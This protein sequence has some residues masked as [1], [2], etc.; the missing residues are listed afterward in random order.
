[1]G[2]FSAAIAF[3]IETY[4]RLTC[5]G[6]S[7]TA[8]ATDRIPGTGNR[9]CRGTQRCPHDRECIRTDGRQRKHSTLLRD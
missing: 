7:P 8:A 2:W 6:I 1:V 3:I 5:K 4:V 9:D